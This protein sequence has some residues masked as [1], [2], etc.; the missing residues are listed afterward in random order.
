MKRKYSIGKLLSIVGILILCAGLFFS[1]IDFISTSST[2]F[3]IIIAV[4][5]ITEAVALVFIFKKNKF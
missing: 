4:G 5:I 1:G 3:R 2:V